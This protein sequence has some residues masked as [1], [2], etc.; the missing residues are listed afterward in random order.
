MQSHRRAVLRSIG[1][2]LSGTVLLGN[3]DSVEA[4]PPIE[5]EPAAS[6]NYRRAARTAGD[7]DWLVVHTIEGSYRSGINTFKNPATNV[8][9][10]YVV[11]TAPGQITQMVDDS[12][13]AWTAGNSDYNDRSINVELAGYASSGFP[14]QQYDNVTALVEFL[15][16]TYTIPARHPEAAVA[17]CD[18]AAGQGGVIGHDQ[19]PSPYDCSV[20][21]GA[22]RHTD[23]GPYFEY[24]RVLSGGGD[25]GGDDED[26][27]DGSEDGDPAFQIGQAVAATTALNTRAG[28]RLDETVRETVSTGTA[29]YVTDG[30]VTSGGYTWWQMDWETGTTGW[31]V[32]R[33]LD[34]TDS[35]DRPAA[36]DIGES[37]AATTALNTRAGPRLDEAVRE[38]VFS[39]ATGSITDGYVTSDG[40]TWWQVGWETQTTGWSVERYLTAV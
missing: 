15:T 11:G 7:I 17:P 27:D 22:G 8:S 4:R 37:V 33:Y 14:D 20:G 1:A 36:F 21:G 35:V 12:D 23:P 16:D 18:A 25:G 34:E 40:Y 19:V 13:V 5:Q 30:Y 10:H 2:T 38:T 28:P 31:S 39:G 24:D 6:S 32:E 3:R 9:A 26:G 29:G